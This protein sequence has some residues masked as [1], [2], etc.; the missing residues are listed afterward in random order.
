MSKVGK[1]I[2]DITPSTKRDDLYQA[3]VEVFFLSAGGISDMAKDEVSWIMPHIDAYARAIALEAIGEDERTSIS[4]DDDYEGSEWER[5]CQNQRNG[6]R[7]EQ[8]SR[9][10]TLLSKP[11][12]E[13]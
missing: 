13:E 3:L 5:D 8:R 1:T 6:V 11:K 12:G 7:A 4:P 9:L 2:D 10:D